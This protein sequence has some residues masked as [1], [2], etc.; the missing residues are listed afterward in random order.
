[1]FVGSKVIAS[2]AAAYVRVPPLRGV[3]TADAEGA[4]AGVAVG[5]H[6]AMASAADAPPIVA[7][8]FLLVY[9]FNCLPPH[10]AARMGCAAEPTALTG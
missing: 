7:S 9:V 1:M 2:A 10:A 4:G 5:A 3:F 6:A 8:A